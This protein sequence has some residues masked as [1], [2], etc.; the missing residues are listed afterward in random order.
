MSRR[1]SGTIDR[2]ESPERSDARLRV[3]RELV[4]ECQALKPPKHFYVGASPYHE[5]YGPH[6]QKPGCG[7][8]VDDPIHLDP[9]PP[10][11]GCR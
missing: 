3:L 8:T 7:G 10:D 1:L 5:G 6:C 4:A 2:D 9:G 11:L